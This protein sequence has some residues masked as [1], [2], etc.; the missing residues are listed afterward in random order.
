MGRHGFRVYLSPKHSTS[1]ESVQVASFQHH[2]TLTPTLIRKPKPV[3]AEFFAAAR[4]SASDRR[5]VEYRARRI[6]VLCM[7]ALDEHCAELRA[8]LSSPRRVLSADADD[9]AQP[10]VQ[11]LLALAGACGTPPDQR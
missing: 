1:P 10:L 9:V 4:G 8:S 2:N 11:A 6:A 3:C 5:T 7:L